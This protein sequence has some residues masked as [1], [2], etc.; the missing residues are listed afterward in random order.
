MNK[1]TQ[2]VIEAKEER[3]ELETA[4]GFVRYEFVRKLTPS[5]FHVIWDQAI[6]DRKPFDDIIDEEI[7]KDGQ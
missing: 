5:M 2:K 7:E 6:K 3:T 1:I 4:L